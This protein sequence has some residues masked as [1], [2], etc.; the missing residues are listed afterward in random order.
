M[1]NPQR[2]FAQDQ[3]PEADAPIHVAFA[4]STHTVNGV[5]AATAS[6][7]F[8][9][10]ASQHHIIATSAEADATAIVKLPS[11]AEAVGQFYYIEAPTGATAG[12]ISV[13]D[14]EAGTE[15][16]TYGDLD[17]DDDH[18]LFYCTGTKW[19]MIFDGVA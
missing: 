4:S 17:A 16:T 3:L 7:T 12:D 8:Q 15:I 14:K 1:G 5:A 6:S 13:Y 11:K 2:R 9:M 10:K 19:L 18:V